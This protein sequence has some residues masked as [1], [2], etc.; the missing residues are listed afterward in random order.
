VSVSLSVIAALRKAGAR[1]L[2]APMIAA[3]G[4]HGISSCRRS[5]NFRTGIRLVYR[6]VHWPASE[7]LG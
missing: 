7:L 5:G 2:S 1:R 4:K 6:L 3:E